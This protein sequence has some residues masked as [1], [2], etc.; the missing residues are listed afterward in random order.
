MNLFEQG[1]VALITGGARGIG[2]ACAR[3]LALEGVK[4]ALVDINGDRVRESAENLTNETGTAAIGIAA[5]I[6]SETDVA[7]MVKEATGEFGK[8]DL[9]LNSAA[10]L[11]DKT[12]LES[13]PA[14]WDRMLKICLYGPM[15]CLHAILPGMIERGYGRVVCM[16]SDSARVGQ[17]RLSYYAASKA[18]VIALCKSVAQEVGK[19]GVT[20]NVVSPGATNTEL[21]QDREASLRQSMGEEKYQRRVNTVLRMYPVGRIGEPDDSASMITFLLSDKA[22]WVTGQVVSVNGGFLMM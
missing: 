10:I 2:Y 1:R 14:E 19:S 16:A 11:A 5:D 21:R 22:G 3:S 6:S 7:R 13:T 9:F 17:A 12:F 20:L 18:G 8:I 4:V 15:L